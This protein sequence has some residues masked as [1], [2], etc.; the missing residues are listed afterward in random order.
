LVTPN[1]KPLCDLFSK[2]FF[3]ALNVTQPKESK[4]LNLEVDRDDSSNNFTNL[5]PWIR[6]NDVVV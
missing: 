4:V 3:Y 1:Q 2:R 5:V 6:A